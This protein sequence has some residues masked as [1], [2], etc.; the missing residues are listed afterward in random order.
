[1]SF[2]FFSD[3]VENYRSFCTGGIEGNCSLGTA[4]KSRQTKKEERTL[5]QCHQLL[6][7]LLLLLDSIL[8]TI[9]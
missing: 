6:L 8:C 5:V 7:P 9:A 3:D 1:M 2:R 4:E